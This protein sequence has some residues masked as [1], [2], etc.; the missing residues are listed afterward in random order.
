VLREAISSVASQGTGW[1]QREIIHF[2]K[3]GQH[4]I[5]V[6]VFEKHIEK[7]TSGEMFT[8]NKFQISRQRQHTKGFSL[9]FIFLELTDK[10]QQFT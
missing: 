2:R 3:L 4:M 10:Q 8:E 5:K 7:R 1:N 9:L 6:I